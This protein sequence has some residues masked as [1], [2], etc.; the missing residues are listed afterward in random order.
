MPLAFLAPLFAAGLLAIAIPVL[1]HLVHKERKESVAFPSLMFVARSPYQ[2][3]RRQRIRDVLLFAAR[4]LIIAL[5]VAAFARPLWAPGDARAAAGTGARDVVLLL[6]RSLSMRHGTRWTE[7]RGA[8][9]AVV[10]GIGPR[11]RLT[12]IPFDTRASIVN[13]ST[14]D[15]AALRAAL[16]TL[17]P[18]DVGTRLAPAVALA[19]RVLGASTLPA[20]E[21]V[22]VSDFQRS[23]W[24]LGDEVEM[25][26]GTVITPIDVGGEVESDRSVRGVETRRAT[27]EDGRPTA[28]R[29]IVS[30]RIVNVG[31]AA[32]GVGVTLEIAGRIAERRT[33]DLAADG[34]TSVSFS[35]V[36]IPADGGGVPARVVL[37][38]DAFPADDAFH[39]LL[40]RAPTVRVLL[41]EHGDTPSDRGVFVSRALAIGDAP[42][43]E[44]T[45]VSHVRA[46]TADLAGRELVI[47]NDAGVPPGIG[48]ERLTS[49]VRSG[50]GLL[51]ALGERTSPREWPSSASTLL[52]GEIG[53]PVDRLGAR[54]AVLGYLDRTHP[55]LAVFEAARSGDLSGAR[56]FRYRP[57]GARE[58]S[59][60]MPAGRSDTE[61]DVLARFDD[62]AGALV[63]HRVGRGRVLTWASSFDGYWN[64]LPRQAVFLPFLHQLSR[65][66]AAYRARRT[67]YE[68]GEPVDLFDAA[69]AGA[70][71][72]GRRDQRF[73]VLAP[74]GARLAVGGE[75]A[76]GALEPRE[77]GLYEVRRSGAPNERPRII[78]VNVAPAEV[79]FASFDPVRLTAAL[80]PT[81]A[82]TAAGDAASDPIVVAEQRERE[83]SLWWYLLV[84]VGTLLL[85]EAIL[86]GRASTRRVSP[87]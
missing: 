81:D 13:E 39:V 18:G 36:A 71:D 77:T 30:A 46:T 72:S 38:A 41:V 3:S 58:D 50:G 67:A 59:A 61:R 6:D 32:K 66:A 33:V 62:G 10:E 26:T 5:L 65:H 45:T 14:S 25:P 84:V 19:R 69:G 80:S 23:A 57:I 20:R 8:A 64:D 48:G 44:V 35:A 16:D 34:G 9:D 70:A 15:R 87:S 49:F 17:R 60:A 2:H 29:M 63:E 79:E 54:G 52:P 83:Q 85:V 75:D 55:A 1:V 76:P 86:A 42:A 21:L 37:D 47:L 74:S 7:A 40:T 78:P 28:D 51:I 31:A 12:I 82:G 43:F 73:A 53:A 24:D 11:D 56:F 22:V 68:V 27:G 4:S